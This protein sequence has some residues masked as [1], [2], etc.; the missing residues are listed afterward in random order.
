MKTALFS[1]NILFI[2]LLGSPFLFH[3]YAQE[4]RPMPI[5]MPV[6]IPPPI[7]LPPLHDPFPTIDL[8]PAPPDIHLPGALGTAPDDDNNDDNSGAN[9]VTPN[10]A[11]GGDGGG[12]PEPKEAGHPHHEDTANQNNA[13]TLSDTTVINAQ[14]NEGADPPIFSSKIFWGIAILITIFIAVK[15]GKK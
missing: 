12:G 9:A 7:I 1:L 3:A 11:S 14:K 5:D 10:S 13:V 15:M 2:T 6:Y 8:P 4:F